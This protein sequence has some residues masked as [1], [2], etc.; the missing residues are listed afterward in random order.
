MI[1]LLQLFFTYQS[2]SIKKILQQYKMDS[3]NQSLF[4]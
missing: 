4:R 1:I 2:D 3:Y